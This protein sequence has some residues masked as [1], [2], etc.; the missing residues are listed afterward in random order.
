MAKL[1]LNF[2]KNRYLFD[3]ALKIKNKHLSN[4]KALE[5]KYNFLIPK[6]RLLEHTVYTTRRRKQTTA[7]LLARRSARR[8]KHDTFEINKRDHQT[9]PKNW[10]FWHAVRCNFTLFIFRKICL[11]FSWAVIF[12]TCK[13]LQNTTTYVSF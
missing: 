5:S 7:T 2:T 9:Q 10:K 4:P 6:P 3:I 11:I 1:N 12:L 13:T 8:I